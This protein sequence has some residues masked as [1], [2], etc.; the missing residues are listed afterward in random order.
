MLIRVLVL[1]TE[2]K[3]RVFASR[4]PQLP[5]KMRHRGER[6]PYGNVMDDQCF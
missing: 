2:Q 5:P 3:R 4:K 1:F 6:E